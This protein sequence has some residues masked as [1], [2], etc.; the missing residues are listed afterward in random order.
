MR[1]DIFLHFLNRDTREIFGVYEALHD[2]SHL[3]LMRRALNAAIALCEDRCIAPPGFV[4]ED[5]IA[6]ELAEAQRAYLRAGVIQFPMRENSLAEYAEKKRIGYE[7]MRNRYSGLFD[8]TRIGFLGENATGIIGRKVHITERILADWQSGPEAGQKIWKPVKGKLNPRLVDL[9]ARIP[10]FLN[11]RG[12]ALTWAAIQPELSDEA[13]HAST[14]LRDALQHIYFQQYCAEFKLLV[15]TQI[16]HIIQDFQLPRDP[17]VYSYRRLHAFLDAFDLR[18]LVLDGPAELIVELRRGKGFISFM[19]AYAG[20]ARITKSETDLKFFAGRARKATNFDWSTLA[21]RRIRLFALSPIEVKELDNVLDEAAT[22]L[23]GEHGLPVRS[24]AKPEAQPRKRKAIAMPNAEPDLVLF[25][26]L[27]EEL[28]ILERQLGFTKH[29]LSPEATGKIGE[30]DVAV[31]CPKVMG[32]VP[33][34]VAV[35][36]Y[37]AR[38]L[39]PPKL[40]L[41]IGLAGGFEENNTRVGHTICA[42][43]VIDLASRK[44]VDDKE[45]ASTKFRRRDFMMN[46]AL[47]AVLSSNAFDENA[48]SNYAWENF[49]WPKDQRP[50]IHMGPLASGDEVVSSHTWRGQM[51][52]GPGGHEKLLGVEMEAGGVCAA[53]EKA[54]VPCCMLRVVSDNADPSKADD[55]WRR[56]GMRGLAN[57]LARL[58]IG[59]VFEAI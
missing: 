21:S 38:R 34:A 27:D 15:L 36:N 45:L 11:D 53:A 16:P 57:L 52:S 22:R 6:F 39:K 33:A 35:A 12:I 44:V 14:E 46:G 40:I 29:H 1:S 5:Q 4:V 13:L 31:I 51:L 23:V 42:T 58:P 3:R 24:V 18:S 20:L 7:P 17:A 2:D 28:D 47:S 9:V 50:S 56:R 25:V 54:K 49:D 37:L 10:C 26:A 32:R 48:W 55:A 59:K 19:D 30:V 43:E 41:I 8:D